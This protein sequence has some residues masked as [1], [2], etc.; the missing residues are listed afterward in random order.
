MRSDHPTEHPEEM[1]NAITHAAGLLLAIA[2][3][4]FLSRAVLRQGSPAQ[5]WACA[6][7]ATTLV[8]T[9]F[10]STLSHVAREPRV[11]AAMRTV[12][13]AAIF[14]LIAGTYT[15]MAVTWLHGGEWWML[16]VAMWGLAL[17]GFLSKVVWTHRV[18]L[19]TVSTLLYVILGGIPL[20]MVFVIPAG[21]LRWVVAGDLCFCL[22]ILF[23]NFDHR[24]RYFHATWHLLVMGGTVCHFLGILIYCASRAM[25]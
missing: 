1:A 2:G 24:I 18:G 19:G 10:A 9:Y 12:D 23:F 13:Q 4:F 17:A 8:L 25:A 3:T 11:R 21:L 7:Y 20:P 22:G 15:P 16:D 5:I 6:L 14:L